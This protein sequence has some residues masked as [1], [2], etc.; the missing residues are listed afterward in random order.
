MKNVITDDK[1]ARSYWQ[2]FNPIEQKIITEPGKYYIGLSA[3]KTKKIASLWRAR[4]QIK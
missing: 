3:K 4:L 2:K 1:E